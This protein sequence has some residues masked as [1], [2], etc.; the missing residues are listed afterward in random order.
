MRTMASSRL[1]RSV[2]FFGCLVAVIGCGKD[3]NPSIQ[4]GTAAVSARQVVGS[5]EVRIEFE[6]N[7][8]LQLEVDDLREGETVLDVM[9]RL[10]DLNVVAHGEGEFAFV[11]QIG[12]IAAAGSEGW[13][14]Y[15][16]DQWAE[17]SAGI[18]PLQAGDRIRWKYG[19]F[20]AE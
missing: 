13:L 2:L 20:G 19:R 3:S 7:N 4:E 6:E 16:N 11:S 14:F 10:P 1:V 9:R 15:V 8:V 17:Q 5:V 18:T 12:E